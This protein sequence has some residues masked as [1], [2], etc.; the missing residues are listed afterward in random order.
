[1]LHIKKSCLSS[2]HCL[3][4]ISWFPIPPGHSFD[5]IKMDFEYLLQGANTMNNKPEHTLDLVKIDLV[6]TES[7]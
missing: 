4:I 5:S 1:M 3:Y 2:P 6:Y 7:M